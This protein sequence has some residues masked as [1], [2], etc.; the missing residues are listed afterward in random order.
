MGASEKNRAVNNESAAV[1]ANTGVFTP[2]GRNLGSELGIRD[3]RKPI[4]QIASNIP[5][6]PP[7]AAISRLSVSNW[8]TRR[9]RLAPRAARTANSCSRV[10]ALASIRLARFAQAISRTNPTAP[11]RISSACLTSPTSCSRTGITFAPMPLLTG[12]SFSTSEATPDISACA[13]GTVTPGFRRATT[14]R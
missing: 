7:A 6:S 1:K 10:V 12:N 11:S 3:S 4:P 13:C 5:P 2:I 9:E 14:Y 8:R